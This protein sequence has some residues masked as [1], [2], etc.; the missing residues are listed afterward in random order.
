MALIDYYNRSMLIHQRFVLSAILIVTCITGDFLLSKIHPPRPSYW[1]RAL[2]DNGT[3]G[4]VGLLSW[5][6]VINPTLLPFGALLENEFLWEIILCG[7]LSSLVDL[8]HFAAAGTLNLQKTLSLQ[9]R[10]PLHAATLI[11]VFCV[12]LLLVV[13]LLKLPRLH[14]LPL[15]LFVA[16][17]SHLTRDA[18]RRGFWLWPWNS[19]SRLPYLSY[20]FLV[21]VLPYLVIAFM[22]GTSYWHSR[23]LDSKQIP[24]NVV[25]Q[26]V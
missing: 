14:H 10:P 4:L 21:A 5:A 11:P 18:T 25:I 13:R 7:I 9:S 16:W 3:H 23:L 24:R 22:N 2:V 26:H 12:L 20:I 1:Y 6:I 17:F 19:M 8:D 15:I